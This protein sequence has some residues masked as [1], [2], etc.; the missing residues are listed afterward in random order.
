MSDRS[1]FPAHVLRL[2]VVAEA[3][4]SVLPRIL[5]SFQHLNLVPRR[6][7]AEADCREQLYVEVDIADF[8]ESRL[9]IITARIAQFPNV[10]EAYW[11]PI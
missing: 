4:P 1:D 7:A 11:H 5:A 6:V 8:S 2:R 3:D 9:A 10:L